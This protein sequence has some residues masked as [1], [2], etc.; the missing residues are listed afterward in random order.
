MITIEHQAT[1][2]VNQTKGRSLLGN[3]DPKGYFSESGLQ[4]R[5]LVRG[6]DS[7]TFMWT[8][9]QVP[10]SRRLLSTL[11]PLDP[12]G[13]QEVTQETRSFPT[14][15][16]EIDEDNPASFLPGSG[17]NRL[18]TAMDFWGK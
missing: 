13:N 2:S 1:L 10:R 6:N 4:S 16:H 9:G 3:P 8:G 12:S 7:S 11:S 18:E 14:I 17:G 5:E 15:D